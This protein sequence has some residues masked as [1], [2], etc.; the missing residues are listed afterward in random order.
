MKRKLCGIAAL[1]LS[2]VLLAAFLS[3]CSKKEESP[4][5]D[6]GSFVEQHVDISKW[7]DDNDNVMFV[8]LGEREY[9]GVTYD[10]VALGRYKDEKFSADYYFYV[11]PDRSAIYLYDY[12]GGRLDEK[13]KK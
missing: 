6:L 13:W 7:F 10:A 4:S 1:L 5:E 9:E 8:A 3:A 11:L 2:A 12:V